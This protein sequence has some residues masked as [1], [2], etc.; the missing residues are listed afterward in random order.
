MKVSELF[1]AKEISY[2]PDRKIVMGDVK[3]WLKEFGATSEDVEKAIRQFKGTPLVRNE[4][5]KAGLN[6][7]DSESREKNGTL[8]FYAIFPEGGKFG[9]YKIYANGQLRKQIA[10]SWIGADAH[11]RLVSPKPRIVPGNP[12]ASLVRTYTSA[13]EELLSKW[14]K[15]KAAQVKSNARLQKEQAKNREQAS[16]SKD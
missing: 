10:K 14:N 8:T 5:P 16:R 4:M 1:E 15:I 12:V 13:A 7:F 9:E 2:D 11:T 6:F 3:A